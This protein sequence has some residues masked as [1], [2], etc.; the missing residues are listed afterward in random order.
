MSGTPSRKH[1][2]RVDAGASPESQI[3]FDL[4]SEY[5]DRGFSDLPKSLQMKFKKEEQNWAK[6]TLEARKA[7]LQAG[8][9]KERRCVDL[10]KKNWEQLSAGL[11]NDI[12]MF[13][14]THE[15]LSAPA[16]L[17]DF[18]LKLSIA[19][20]SQLV[21][22][23]DLIAAFEPVILADEELEEDSKSVEEADP[24]SDS[25]AAAVPA[26]VPA[27]EAAMRAESPEI[28]LFVEAFE[29]RNIESSGIFKAAFARHQEIFEVTSYQWGALDNLLIFFQFDFPK[30]QFFF[31]CVAKNM[32]CF[33]HQGMITK[34]SDHGFCDDEPLLVEWN[35]LD[36]SGK[37]EGLL[38]IADQIFDA[39]TEP[40]VKASAKPS[41]P[42]AASTVSEA[43]L[44]AGSE[45]SREIK[46]S[47]GTVAA[48]GGAGA[49]PALV[50]SKEN[51]APSLNRVLKPNTR[52]RAALIKEIQEAVY[53]YCNARSKLAFILE[54]FN[55]L[56]ENN[57]DLT[58]LP[59]SEIFKITESIQALCA[60]ELYPIQKIVSASGLNNPNWHRV[61][62]QWTY[63]LR[64]AAVLFFILYEKFSME[65]RAELFDSL[66]L[67][68]LV[69]L[70]ASF[71]A[72]SGA[73]AK[74]RAGSEL[75]EHD[76]SLVFGFF[77]LF[78]AVNLLGGGFNLSAEEQALLKP[79]N[80]LG[81]RDTADLPFWKTVSQQIQKHFP[82]AVLE[83]EVCPE[84]FWFDYYLELI[85]KDGSALYIA[86][87][88]DGSQYHTGP[89]L[90]KDM[91]RDK[92]CELRGVI[93]HRVRY[94]V[95]RH[96]FEMKPQEF[97]MEL[98]AKIEVK[99]GK[100]VRDAC[101]FK[102][103][104]KPHVDFGGAVRPK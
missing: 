12:A 3:K 31:E 22:L 33:E 40:E 32:G 14:I 83:R 51:Y 34:R 45:D 9:L 56:V 49:E 39:M 61:F 94:D 4:P 57:G 20:R 60:R 36:A 66:R 44:E 84:G 35:R 101:V 28:D 79:R 73:I 21:V 43:I 81:K 102:T 88:S 6:K 26:A 90:L 47:P 1:K 5:V 78:Y 37:L 64:D 93:T 52:K 97:V 62:F 48:S 25:I 50:F 92:A 68:A 16:E 11:Q 2:A 77:S 99:L 10:A 24:V 96:Q 13:A 69:T 85:S 17:S 100:S 38:D 54:F 58:K 8:F 46:T 104:D 23:V 15:Y 63:W 82:G 91:A 89:Q 53:A 55:F 87:E 72:M 86:L 19:N 76:R 75:S 95:S 70:R 30:R 65:V 7:L 67:A 42:E 29:T 98:I 41:T 71:P 59:A 103:A 27:T 80:D 18:W 74:Y